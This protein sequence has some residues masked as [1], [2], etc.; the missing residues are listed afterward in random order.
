MNRDA[1]SAREDADESDPADAAGVPAEPAGRGQ[2]SG[3]AASDGH[4]A[5]AARAPS[6]DDSAPLRASARHEPTVSPVAR[7][8]G[9]GALK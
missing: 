4:P 3:H 2:E 5:A 6:A 8:A 7:Q 1:A 9:P